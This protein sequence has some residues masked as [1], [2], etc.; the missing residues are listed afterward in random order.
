MNAGG[1]VVK[2]LALVAGSILFVLVITLAGDRVFGALRQPPG[3]PETLELIFP[4]F[5]EQHFETYDFH[6]SV[7]I[8]SIGI[9]DRELPRERGAAYRVLAIGD[10]YTYGWGVN[11][12]D[13]WMRLL[14]AR[15]REEGH[16]IKILNLGK[17]GVGPP[18]YAELAEKAIPLLRPDLVLVCM[19]QGND[20]RA[21]GPEISDAPALD[22]WDRVRTLYPNFTLL[23][24][25]LRR[26]RE[27]AGRTHE[28]MPPQVSSA[29]D[30][31]RWTAA[32]AQTFLE[33]MPPEHRA[34]FDAFDETVREAYSSGNLNPYMIDLAMQNPDFYIL[35]MDVEDAW[36]QTCIERTASH[37]ARIR[38]VAEEYNSEV[39]VLSVPE[40]PYVN[41]HAL[42]NMGRVGYNVPGWLLTT[43]SMDESIR[44]A[45]AL[46]DLPFYEVTRHFRARQD[47]PDLYFELD[48]HP[49]AAGN[50]LF[51]EAFHPLLEQIISRQ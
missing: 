23:M 9:R 17:P 46:A 49:T 20:I 43:D 1:T 28:D 47:D 39:A 6:Y 36:T 12:E 18:F 19:L 8:N 30:N 2:N 26:E 10:S 37:F 38:R 40:G 34:R 45:A 14:E 33:N 16:E 4:P 51:A 48:G 15:M 24:R 50:T 44:R 41:R 32:T 35:T 22:F 11:I 13:T 25:D 3:L 27:Y 21:A 42:A 29:E 7:H 5:S 31:R